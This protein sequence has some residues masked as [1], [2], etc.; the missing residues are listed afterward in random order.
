MQVLKRKCREGTGVFPVDAPVH[1]ATVNVQYSLHEPSAAKQAGSCIFTGSCDVDSARQLQATFATGEGCMAAAIEMA[2]RLM[3]PG[4]QSEV[5]FEEQYGFQDASEVPEGVPG[6]RAM[7]AMLTLVSFEKEGHPQ[8]MNADEVCCVVFAHHTQTTCAIS[9]TVQVHMI[10]P[11]PAGSNL[12]VGLKEVIR[13]AD[14]KV[15][16][17]EKGPGKR[18]V[19]CWQVHILSQAL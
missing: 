6:D 12:S 19:W 9:N 18:A 10:L 14:D 1:D 13:C 16:W 8:A 3:L 2:V 11:L 15:L 4:E 5:Y 7:V 17:K